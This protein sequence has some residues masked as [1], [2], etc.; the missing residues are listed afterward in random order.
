[1]SIEGAEACAQCGSPIAAEDNFC[2]SCGTKKVVAQKPTVAKKKYCE[3]CSAPADFS[4]TEC[5]NCFGTAFTHT[6]P[7]NIDE[8]A[9]VTEAPVHD[10]FK[11]ARPQEVA[12]PS[13][14]DWRA[15]KKLIIG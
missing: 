1:M 9:P 12:A 8:S 15:H 7:E 3:N 10:F 11:A 13:E 2:S 4:V 6:K 5:G 14:F